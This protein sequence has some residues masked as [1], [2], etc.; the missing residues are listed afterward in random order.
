VFTAEGV[1]RRAARY[2]DLRKLLTHYACA[3]ALTRN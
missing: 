3:V 1:R 2:V